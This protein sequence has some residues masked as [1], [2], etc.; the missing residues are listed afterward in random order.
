MIQQDTE[1]QKNSNIGKQKVTF[2]FNLNFPKGNPIS[3]IKKFLINQNLWTEEEDKALKIDAKKKVM[4]SLEK[5][6]HEEKVPVSELFTDVYDKKP[7][8]LVEQENE[9]HE[10]LS[11][12]SKYY[13]SA[14]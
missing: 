5:I 4:Q 6:E 9:L 14:H 3:R 13:E 1:N 12:Y 11:K 7:N 8:S 2:E 10:H